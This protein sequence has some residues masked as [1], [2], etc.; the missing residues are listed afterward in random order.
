MDARNTLQ[1][2]PPLPQ[3][4]EQATLQARLSLAMY[5]LKLELTAESLS[6]ETRVGILTTSGTHC[7]EFRAVERRDDD[8]SDSDD[9]YEGDFD[10]GGSD[11]FVPP[12]PS[13]LSR[14]FGFLRDLKDELLPPNSRAAGAMHTQMAS[15]RS[16]S[17]SVV[18]GGG[19]VV[20]Q[21][22]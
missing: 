14:M 17:E 19:V 22:F 15:R 16:S 5:L 6:M 7:Y 3:L 20:L 11:P 18:S 8:D 13:Q 21:H 4:S 1:P 9:G 2:P 10:S 12:V